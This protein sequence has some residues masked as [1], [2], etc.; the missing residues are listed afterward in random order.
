MR[1]LFGGSAAGAAPAVNVATRPA[2]AN[3]VGTP[4]FLLMV[5]L[6]GFPQACRVGKGALFGGDGLAQWCTRRA[7]ALPVPLRERRVGTAR[8]SQA[9]ADC[10]DLSACALLPTLHQNG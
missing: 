9:C 2:A 6:P 7:H 5:F 1:M 3:N 10:V 4:H 8:R